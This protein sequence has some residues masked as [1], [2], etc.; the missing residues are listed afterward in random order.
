MLTLKRLAVYLITFIIC[1]VLALSIGNWRKVD[2]YIV[3]YSNQVS[4]ADSI[5]NKEIVFVHLDQNPPGESAC[6]T[7]YLK[8]RNTI[9]LLNAVAIQAEQNNGPKGVVLDI[10]FGRDNTEQENLIAAINNLQEKGTPVYA[11]Y[12]INAAREGVDIDSVDIETLEAAHLTEVYNILANGGEAK[13]PGSGRYHTNFYNERDMASYENDYYFV[14]NAFG[15]STQIESLVYKIAHDLGDSRTLLN[16]V[17][18]RGSITPYASAEEMQSHSYFFAADAQLS[19]ESFIPYDQVPE[20][21]HT[22]DMDKKIMVVGD[23]LNDIIGMGKWAIPGPYV[24][25][26]AISDLLDMNN[27]LKLPLESTPVI[28]GQMLFFSFFVALAFALFFKYIKILQTKPAIIALLSFLVSLLLL[29]IYYRLILTFK[30][31]IPVGQTIVTMIVAALLC[32]R[33]AYKFLVTGIV[34]GAGKYDVFISYS[35]GPQAEWV[36]KNVYEPL[37]AYRKPSGDRLNIF[38]DKKSI[39]IG[40]AFTSRYMWAIVDTKCFIPVV[41]DEYYG[42]NHCRNELDL[43]VNRYVEKRINI[44]ML[45]FNYEAV[46]EP[47]RTFN[48]IE[49]GKNPD[50]INIITSNLRD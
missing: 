13:H 46:P 49:V 43:A 22:I 50:F 44:N 40:E 33:F 27:R 28:I 41:T 7:F 12:N 15:D 20:S 25:T 30:A 47:Y 45:A 11:A 6:E 23:P 37:A 17:K 24:L 5:V 19:L 1:A 4:K 36:E 18:R 21:R 42:K 26:W 38:F 2:N 31:V 10:W 29:F 35:H 39:G 32:W 9:D 34:E 14:S 8:R 16:E 48:Y 3:A